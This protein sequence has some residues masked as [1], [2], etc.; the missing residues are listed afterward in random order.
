MFIIDGNDLIEKI[1][2]TIS[3]KFKRFFND[4]IFELTKEECENS[5]IEIY[6]YNTNINKLKYI[7]RLKEIKLNY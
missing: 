4:D 3:P 1:E 5:F 2:N 7:E 6:V